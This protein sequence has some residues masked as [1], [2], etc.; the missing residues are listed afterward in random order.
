M[1]TW[2]KADR[3]RPLRIVLTLLVALLPMVTL[4]QT[5][6]I[7]EVMV[8]GGTE[9]QVNTLKTSLTGQGWTVIGK[10][11]NAGAG[12]DYIY[13]LYKS[14]SNDYGLNLGYITDFYIST[15]TGTAPDTRT[16]NGR[17]YTLVPYQG[18]SDFVNSKGDLN[19]GA[20]G[21]YIHL[22]Y[23]KDVFSDNHMVSSISFNGTQTGAVGA[24]GGSTGYDL[25][26]GAE[27]DYIYMHVTTATAPVLTSLQI[28]DGDA[29]T[30]QLPL[31]T[32]AKPRPILPISR[33]LIAFWKASL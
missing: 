4:G 21:D 18:G 8:I 17:T 26:K 12:G 13:L 20:G 24:D 14:E 10:D 22:Y 19:R 23:T 2:M 32:L 29:G 31:S 15:Q 7:K 9:N 27:G 25:N 30:Y 33:L 11:L 1:A 3:E 28:G 16:V 6:G 5:V